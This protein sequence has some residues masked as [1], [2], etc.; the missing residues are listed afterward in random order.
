MHTAALVALAV[1][2]PRLAHLTGRTGRRLPGWLPTVL[3]VVTVLEVATMYAQ[4]FIVP[5]LARVAPAALDVQEIGAFAISMMVIWVAYSLTMV[6]LAVVGAF[7]RV[8]PVAAAAPLAL[9][10]LV[11][12]VFGPVGSIL[13]GGALLGWALTRVLREPADAGR[14]GVEDLGPET[15]S[16]ATAR[17]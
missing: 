10:A 11:I 1:L 3:T 4:A 7:R 13:I 12:P 6:A 5:F 16:T 8:V 14:T 2:A 15:L 17:A 9:G